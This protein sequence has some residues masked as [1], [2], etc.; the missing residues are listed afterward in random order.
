MVE[1]EDLIEIAILKKH[2][3]LFAQFARN[4]RLPIYRVKDDWTDLAKVALNSPVLT[5]LTK[6]IIN[7]K[8]GREE[9]VTIDADFED[10]D[11]EDDENE[12]FDI[13]KKKKDEKEADNAEKK[14]G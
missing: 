9:D 2:A 11:N 12:E 8:K 3:T 7:I 4:N 14:E 6:G 13:P 10:I 5:E 1:K